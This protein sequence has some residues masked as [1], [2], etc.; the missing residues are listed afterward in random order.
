LGN[1]TGLMKPYW[2][3]MVETVLM[4]ELLI[5]GHRIVGLPDDERSTVQALCWK[6][7]ACVA[8]AAVALSMF[9]AEIAGRQMGRSPYVIIRM[10]LHA[11]SFLYALDSIEKSI[12]VLSRQANTPQAVEDTLQEWTA[13]FEDVKGIRDTSH[14]LEDRVRGKGRTGK[15]GR[16]PD[17]E[18][19]PMSIPGHF[20][21]S[22]GAMIALESFMGPRRF[23][24]TTADGV[25]REI[26]VSEVWL[27]HA[28]SIVQAVLDAYQWEGW[29]HRPP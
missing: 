14:H 29:A 6:I 4:P 25:Y 3:G 22:E 16:Q 21:S 9:E 8:E 7:P 11:R 23:G 1:L 27:I 28:A 15:G 10:T 18:P 26:E 2:H 20:N 17:I 12:R 5:P 13:F 19:Q 24:S